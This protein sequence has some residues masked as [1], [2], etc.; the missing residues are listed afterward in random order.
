MNTEFLFNYTPSWVIFLFTSLVSFFC[1]EGGFRLG[2]RRGQKFEKERKAPISSI[3]GA[4]LA[5]LAFI[6]A[7][8]FSLAAALFIE[9]R[10][11]VLTDANAIE[12]TYR[13]AQYL[14]EP[15]QT[16]ARELLHEYVKIRIPTINS[17]QM[18]QL[19]KRS[20]ELQDELWAVA[21]EMAKNNTTSVMGGLF[22]SS[23]NEVFDIHA[24]RVMTGV[25]IR[26]PEVIWAA[27]FFVTI[28]SMFA[29]GYYSGLA[30][31]R[32]HAI[33]IAMILIFSGAISLIADLDSPQTGLLRVS[34]QPM[35]DLSNKMSA[36]K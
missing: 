35:I 23:L 10:E 20:E 18:V 22:I 5:L 8:T 4:A 19:L 34:Q 15:Y 3:I 25:H 12:T 24:K 32:S 33:N 17:E 29:M 11:L 30:G 9:R 2:N 6:L 31:A 21:V 7:F 16:K 1:F 14:P 27:L 28:L 13:R 26:I 36:R